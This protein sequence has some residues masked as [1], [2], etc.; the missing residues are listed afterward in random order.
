MVI[1]TVGARRVGVHVPRQSL[2]VGTSEMAGS[3][4]ENTRVMTPV[5]IGL[6]ALSI[7]NT[8]IGTGWPGQRVDP[9]LGVWMVRSTGPAGVPVAS[10]TEFVGGAKTVQLLTTVTNVLAAPLRTVAPF[11]VNAANWT[12][13]DVPVAAAGVHVPTQIPFPREVS[14]SDGSPLENAACT[15]P[16][17]PLRKFPQLS[18]TVTRRLYGCP[19]TT[20][21]EGSDGCTSSEAGVQT[22]GAVDTV[23]LRLSSGPLP[24]GNTIAIDEV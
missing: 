8:R 16:D 6:P 23:R 20:L 3:P 24:D 9:G 7:A 15:D 22:G 19:T 4:F 12:R 11:A 18:A 17:A 13:T 1:L 2:P 21:C 10:P 5:V 14:F